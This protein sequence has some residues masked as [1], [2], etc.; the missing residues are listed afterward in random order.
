MNPSCFFQYLPVFDVRVAS[1]SVYFYQLTVYIYDL[2]AQSTTVKVYMK[3]GSFRD[4]SN[5]ENWTKVYD[6]ASNAGTYVLIDFDSRFNAAADSTVAIYISYG[7]PGHFVYHTAG[8]EASNEDVTIEA[9]SGLSEQTGNMLPS[10]LYNL[11]QNI[12]FARSLQ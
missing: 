9:G 12:H 8:G 4:E 2:L 5:L 3:S 1:R 11:N 7:G 10:A 6:G